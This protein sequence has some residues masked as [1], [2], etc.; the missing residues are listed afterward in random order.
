MDVKQM[1]K[2]VKSHA[3]R[4]EAVY[5]NSLVL[6]FKIHAFPTFFLFLRCW[7]W[8]Q[9]TGKAFEQFTKGRNQHNVNNDS[10]AINS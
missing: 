7:A 8:Q 3:H 5:Y 6:D 1:D 2:T 10:A 4:C 9:N